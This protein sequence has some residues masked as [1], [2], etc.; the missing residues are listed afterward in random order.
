MVSID[1][2]CKYINSNCV[3]CCICERDS[4][5]NICRKYSNKD[6]YKWE[7]DIYLKFVEYSIF[8]GVTAGI[9]TVTYKV[10]DMVSLR[11]YLGCVN[12]KNLTILMNELFAYVKRFRKMGFMHGNLNIDNIFVS[13]VNKKLHFFVIDYS[14]SYNL[15]KRNSVPGYPR[16]SFIGESENKLEYMNYIY[17]DILTLYISIK[18]YYKELK[19]NSVVIIEE[20]IDTYI[21]R[22]IINELF[23]YCKK[24][25][26]SN[27]YNKFTNQ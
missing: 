10:R 21:P 2:E 15:N 27:F 24:N 23:G 19:N 22:D 20:I 4:D 6:I 12:V 13:K 9:D 17:W 11:V 3:Q 8:P 7:T 25:R 5:N 14:N 18:K 16:T 26:W 1:N